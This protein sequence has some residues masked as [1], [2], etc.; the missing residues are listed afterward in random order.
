M[1]QCRENAKNKQDFDIFQHSLY[2]ATWQNNTYNNLPM[3]VKEDE[4][5]GP[6]IIPFAIAMAVS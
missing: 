3:V 2:C 6:C 4:H 5:S 1:K